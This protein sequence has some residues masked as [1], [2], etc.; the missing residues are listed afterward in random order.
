MLRMMTMEI[1]PAQTVMVRVTMMSLSL[2]EVTTPVILC[3]LSLERR[4]KLRIPQEHSR[5][6]SSTGDEKLI[7]SLFDPLLKKIRGSV[8]LVEL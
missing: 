6:E 8:I 2:E 3:S 5:E 4:M 1:V 7:S